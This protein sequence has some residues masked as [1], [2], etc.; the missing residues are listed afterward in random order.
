MSQNVQAQVQTYMQLL[1]QG[2]PAKDAFMQAFPNGVP[3][4]ADRAKEQADANQ[5][6]GYGQV[7]GLLVGALGGKAVYDAVT[8]KPILGG[9]FGKGGAGASTI[10]GGSAAP[11]VAALPDVSAA[12]AGA[13]DALT[14]GAAAA[15]APAQ[16]GFWG[17]NGLLGE[18]AMGPG[19][20]IPG[21]IGVLGA[22]DVLTHDYGAGRNAIEGGLSGAGIGFT[23]GGPVGAG[24]GAG[25]GLG[26]G[27][28]K[29]LGGGK[30]KAQKTRDD[31][32]SNFQQAGVAGP[33]YNVGLAD[34]SAFNI[35][36][37]G[38]AELQNV[39]SNIDGKSTRHPY[40]VDFSHPFGSLSVQGLDPLVRQL[41]PGANQKQISD[42]TG[43]L[44]NAVLSN[45]KSIN[46][47]YANMAEQYKRAGLTPPDF[48]KLQPTPP[49]P[50][51]A[52][53]TKTPIPKTP[54]NAAVVKQNGGFGDKLIGAL[55]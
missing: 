12:G 48:S 22:G 38:H 21:L 55:Y 3:T 46:D 47:V 49:T 17:G 31:I 5:K 14:T 8:G 37:D 51:K 24:I 53:T 26:A 15:A 7:G 6:A 1:Q 41:L 10:G 52:A 34:G 16:V 40:D 30:S 45:A 18:G 54:Y 25:V 20:Y 27:L 33:D 42:A 32:R 28:L 19:A 50:P 43:M 13:T 23:L 2:M 9:L 11:G 35:G 36:L 44:S 4:A 39:G 29:S